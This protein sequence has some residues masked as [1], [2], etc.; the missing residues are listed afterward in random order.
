MAE[1][2]CCLKPT[3]EPEISSYVN[4]QTPL[5]YELASV[6]CSVICNQ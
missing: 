2:N 3:L 1:L 6:G 4:L 5:L